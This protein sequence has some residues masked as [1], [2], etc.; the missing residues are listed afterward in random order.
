MEKMDDDLLVQ[1]LLPLLSDN[2]LQDLCQVNERIRILCCRQILW[3]RKVEKKW[4]GLNPQMKPEL[5]TW[6]KFY[7]EMKYPKIVH[8][9]FDEDVLLKLNEKLLPSYYSSTKM[10]IYYVGKSGVIKINKYDRGITSLSLEYNGAPGAP[11]ENQTL[12]SGDD[13]LGGSSPVIIDWDAPFYNRGTIHNAQLI[14]ITGYDEEKIFDAFVD[15]VK[16]LLDTRDIK[17]LGYR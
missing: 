11:H 1:K 12:V 7:W 9:S 5:M 14:R 17:I 10:S 16:H 13:T 6:R 4:P 8:C 15:V 3:L 2:D